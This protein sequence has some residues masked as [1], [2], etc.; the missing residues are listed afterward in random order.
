[1]VS[2]PW[3]EAL[4]FFMKKRAVISILFSAC[5]SL[6]AGAFHQL[7]LDGDLLTL[8]ANRASLQAILADFVQAGVSVRMDPDVDTRVTGSV[9]NMPVDKAL[10]ELLAPY[11][12]TLAWDVVPGPLGTLERLAEIQVFRR[13]GPRNLKPFM[14]ET[15]FRIA[16]GLVPGGPEFVADEVLLTVAPGTTLDQFRTLLAQIGGTVIGSVPELGVYRIRLPANSNVEALVQALESNPVIS[17]VEPNYAYRLPP[18]ETGRVPDGRSVAGSGIL[19]EGAPPVA[20]LDSGVRSAPGLD[21][22]LVGAFD[23]VHPDRAVDD[24]VGHGTQMAL[25]A[26]GAILPGGAASGGDDAVPVLAI[27]A[28]D[29]NGYTSNY[30]LMR[31]IAH[32]RQEGA[33]VVN[34]S[35]GSDTDSAFLAAAMRQ[36]QAAGLV[37]VASA[38][39][40]PT[41]RPVF[42][43]AYPGVIS[44]AA[45][46]S[47]GTPWP[48]SNHGETV[49]LAAP[50][51]AVLP[52][53]YNGQPG[54][55]AGTSIAGAYVARA[56]ALYLARN[57]NAS[58]D[59]VRQ[60]LL[61][62]V[63]P[64]PSSPV[65][66][67][68]GT[69]D[70][71]AM[72]RL[73]AP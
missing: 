48:Q 32:A 58:A 22:L 39:N 35:W 67:G 23:A 30:T 25:I 9:S 41:G 7:R 6:S 60:A 46:Q 49:S 33:R 21:G 73:L 12:Y 57:P 36:A 45:L 65:R 70:G 69:L 63:S 51:T 55:Y 52:V 31:A 14:P 10:D 34:M 4:G 40:Q 16:R 29:D 20:V 62:A 1:M 5:F 54:G 53:G 72:Q 8:K 17:N 28:F 66:Y 43:A 56:A 37:V 47:D 3:P 38:G 71:G 2:R 61:A 15:N 18:G 26:S 42:P 44:V 11:G 68:T 13:D 27:R 24:R 19:R 64:P 59:R 50:G